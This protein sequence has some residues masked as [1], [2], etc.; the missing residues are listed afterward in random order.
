MFVCSLVW[1]STEQ[2]IFHLKHVTVSEQHIMQGEKRKGTETPRQTG[3][4][5]YSIPYHDKVFFSTDKYARHI[6]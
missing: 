5:G 1:F 6:E 2:W 4:R 3:Q